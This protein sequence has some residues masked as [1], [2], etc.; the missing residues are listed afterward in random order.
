MIRR[1]GN[2]PDDDK[3]MRQAC[4]L[5][6]DLCR[7]EDGELSGSFEIRGYFGASE[8][9]ELAGVPGGDDAMEFAKTLM[10]AFEKGKPPG[11]LL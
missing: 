8:M 1:F 3:I 7:D 2:Q 5:E 6:I 10:A 9:A 4:C 11:A